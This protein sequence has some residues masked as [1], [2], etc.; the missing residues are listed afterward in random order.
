MNL[1]GVSNMK[2]L[3]PRNIA[4][5][6]HFIK[7]PEIHAVSCGALHKSLWVGKIQVFL[8]I[9]YPWNNSGCST[10]SCTS[11]RERWS[12]CIQSATSLRSCKII[13][14]ILTRLCNIIHRLKLKLVTHKNDDPTLTWPVVNGVAGGV[15]LTCV[16]DNGV[17]IGLA[18]PDPPGSALWNR[19]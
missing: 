2:P 7:Y 13:C 19:R 17:K 16:P 3:F 15:R 6:G 4:K 18:P 10:R 12:S 1:C 9:T 5:Y 14:C 8:G 11:L